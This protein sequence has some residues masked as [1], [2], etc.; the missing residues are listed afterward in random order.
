MAKSS[1]EEEEDLIL[2]RAVG[3]VALLCFNRPRRYNAWGLSMI[4][5]MQD[6]I[7]QAAKNASIRAIV[8][9]GLGKYYSSGADFAD[10]ITGPML[11]STIRKLATKLNYVQFD[12]FISCP[13][14]I[15]VAV[16]GPAIG[17]A[18]TSSVLCDV[19]IAN[20]GASFL[21]PFAALGVSPEGC[22]PFT[23]PRLLG[24]KGSRMMLEE[25]RKVDAATALEI[26]LVSEVVP[27]NTELEL[28]GIAAETVDEALGTALVQRAIAIAQEWADNDIPRKS[29]P[30]VGKLQQINAQESEALAD[31]LTSVKFFAA[32]YDFA[33]TK[34]AQMPMWFFWMAQRLQPL[35]AKL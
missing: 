28:A 8:L 9:T 29:M 27:A 18:V 13:K 10:F 17:G 3:D 19:I 20:A 34:N 12:A 14:P 6:A 33:K 11:P 24:D 25:G 15:I 1:T 30:L 26:G 23:F 21:T 31:A 7:G 32:Q 5:A 22:S 4:N 2:T 35:L 16:N